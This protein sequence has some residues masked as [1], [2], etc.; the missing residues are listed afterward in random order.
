MF[1]VMKQYYNVSHI[2]SV[3][4]QNCHL[5]VLTARF[6]AFVRVLMW[7]Q[8]SV[9]IRLICIC[10]FITAVVKVLLNKIV[11]SFFFKVLFYFKLIL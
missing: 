7:V 11:N 3:A 4:V 2:H 5:P 1:H 8:E 6:E 10:F 9:C